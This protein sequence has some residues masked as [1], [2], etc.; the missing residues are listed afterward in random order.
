MT[1]TT[2]R[3]VTPHVLIHHDHG[4]E[5]HP[6]RTFAVAL[7]VSVVV[8]VLAALAPV[9][10]AHAAPAGLTVTR[11]GVVTSS[12]LPHCREEDGSGGPRPC[13]WNVGPGQD[14][15]GYGL[16]YWVGRHGHVHYIWATD[17][18]ASGRWSW[19]NRHGARTYHVT[20]RC[21]VRTAGHRPAIKCPN[22]RR[23]RIAGI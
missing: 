6:L 22:G 18:T 7:A 5:L 15:N 16:A 8:A 14:G 19:V 17:P 12:A 9:G 23:F 3:G 1:D 4:R 20:T 10:I 13:T 11:H 2:S 21:A